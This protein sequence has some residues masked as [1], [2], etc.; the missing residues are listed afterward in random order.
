MNV[1]A[2]AGASRGLAP[3]DEMVLVGREDELASLQALLDD[4]GAGGASLVIYGD[5]GI[6][7][8]ALVDEFG[9]LA[10]ARGVKVARTVGMPAEQAMAFAGLHRLLRPYLAHATSLPAPQRNA[11]D[12]AFGRS[13]AVANDL[14]LV[15]L[16]ALELLADATEG[17]PLLIVVEDAHSLDPDTRSEERR[18]GKECVP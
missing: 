11:L 16:A 6:G 10:R 4:V 14:F 9:R 12:A 8:S 2:S 17:S 7:K 1:S 18:V 13:G 5:P 15:A 3:A